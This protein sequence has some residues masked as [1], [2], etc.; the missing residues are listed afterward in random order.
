MFPLDVLLPTQ[1]FSPS[2]DVIY[3]DTQKCWGPDC[4]AF[5]RGNV[6]DASTGS[7]SPADSAD[8]LVFEND[9]DDRN[10][11]YALQG[12]AQN[13]KVKMVAKRS[14]GQPMGL[15]KKKARH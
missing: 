7:A 8:P 1:A 10:E 4:S 3:T 2:E 11:D 9:A 12:F 14:K 5:V 6:A 13:T 15:S